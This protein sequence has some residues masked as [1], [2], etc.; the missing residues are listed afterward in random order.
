MTAVFHRLAVPTYFGGLPAG[1]DYVNNATSGTP[2][3]ANGA[4]TGG[5]N[6]GSYFVGFD[7][8]ATSANANRP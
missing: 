3:Y 6:V 1:Y 2:A 7:D 5:T 8:D 4:L